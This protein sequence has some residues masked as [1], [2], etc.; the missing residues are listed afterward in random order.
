MDP[1]LAL[2]AS[3]QAAEEFRRDYLVASVVVLLASH[4]IVN[5]FWARAFARVVDKLT[6]AQEARVQDKKED[7]QELA[8]HMDRSTEA[9]TLMLAEAQ[10][11]AR[12]RR[13]TDPPVLGAEPQT[14]AKRLPGGT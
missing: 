2:E 11:R 13:A 14:Q 1:Q 5:S 7:R 8:V 10:Q 9:M 4:A 3:K 12:R 6:A